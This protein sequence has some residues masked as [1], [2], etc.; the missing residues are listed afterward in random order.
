MRV[1]IMAD[2]VFVFVFLIP[3]LLHQ[4]HIGVTYAGTSNFRMELVR[5]VPLY[6]VAMPQSI[7]IIIEPLFVL[8]P[9]HIVDGVKSKTQITR[10]IKFVSLHEEIPREVNKVFAN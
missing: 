5:F 7:I 10:A 2:V 4:N 6:Y 1:Q 9:I 3:S 8:A